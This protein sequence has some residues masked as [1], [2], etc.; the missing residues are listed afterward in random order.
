METGRCHDRAEFYEFDEDRVY[1]CKRWGIPNP[2]NYIRFNLQNDDTYLG[3]DCVET[4]YCQPTT[5]ACSC[6][7]L[8]GGLL[9]NFPGLE[10]SGI[11]LDFQARPYIK[12]CKCYLGAATRAGFTSLN[13]LR[14]TPECP[15]E[16]K[17]NA[18]NYIEECQSLEKK[19]KD[20]CRGFWDLIK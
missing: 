16:T 20:G 9:S 5:E 7:A 18:S 1:A 13:I 14:E 10:I 17:I 11:F 6:K 19:K 3:L 2:G 12:G 4:T 8:L 15:E